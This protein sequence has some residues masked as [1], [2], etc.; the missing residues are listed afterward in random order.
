MFEKIGCSLVGVTCY[1][2]GSN[3]STARK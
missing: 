3:K 2:S 1:T